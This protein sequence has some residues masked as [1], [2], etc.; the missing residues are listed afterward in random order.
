MEVE[1][2]PLVAE[3]GICALVIPYNLS[4]HPSYP[5]PP[6]SSPSPPPPERNGP[7][8]APPPPPSAWG[9]QL[10]VTFQHRKL[11]EQIS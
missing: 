3:L 6:L 10:K 7:P 11:M 8:L 2:P 1:S 4:M 9:E 5:L